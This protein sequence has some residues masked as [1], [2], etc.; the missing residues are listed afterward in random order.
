MGEPADLPSGA[1]PTSFSVQR[2]GLFQ[3]VLTFDT[4][5]TAPVASDL[6]LTNLG[7]I[8]DVDPD[9][10]I[11]LRDEQLSLNSDGLT[12]TIELDA[13]QATDGVYQIQLIDNI[14]GGD[15]FTFTGNETNRFYVLKGDWNGSGGVNIQDFATFA[16]WFGQSVPTAPAYVDL[17]DSGG[18]NIQDFAGFAANFGKSVA[19]PGAVAAVSSNGAA[20]GELHAAMNSLLNP[21]DTNGDGSVTRRD[22]VSI[23]D[24]LQ[25]NGTSE[26]IGYSTLD[27]NRDGNVSARDA[28]YVIN[29]IEL[30]KVISQIAEEDEEDTQAVDELMGNDWIGVELF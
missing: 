10:V 21:T 30:D 15:T 12:L 27:A 13:E 23:I 6:V 14:T 2:S 24:D 17:N 29:R 3:I 18:I 19:F 7:M 5:I 1:Q 28:L 9:V 11:T 20:E 16:Y 8:A 4:P 26:G 22:A 25:R